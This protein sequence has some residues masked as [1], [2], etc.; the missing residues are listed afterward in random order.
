MLRLAV[1]DD[2]A[3]T[4]GAH[5]AAETWSIQPEMVPKH[6][7]QWFVGMLVGDFHRLAIKRDTHLDLR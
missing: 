3:G 4:A 6:E 5:T 2:R 1:D 7:K